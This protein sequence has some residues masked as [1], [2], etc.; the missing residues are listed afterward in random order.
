[1]VNKFRGKSIDGG[2]WVYGYYVFSRGKHYIL[3]IFDQNGYDERWESSEWIEVIPETVGQFTILLDKNVME[4][5]EGDILTIEH[6]DRD[7][8]TTDVK[9]IDGA[10]SVKSSWGEYYPMASLARPGDSL[11]IIGNVYENPELLEATT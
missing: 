3:Q 1:M 11:K 2:I 6:E 9:M 8:I 4:I 7:M 10:F 5:Y